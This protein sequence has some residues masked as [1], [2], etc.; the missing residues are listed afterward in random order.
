MLGRSARA[1]TVW[2][3]LAVAGALAWPRL[4]PRVIATGAYGY[5]QTLPADLDRARF[6][7]QFERSRIEAL[8]H[9]D[10]R[11]ATVTVERFVPTHTIY[12]KTDGKVEGSVPDGTGPSRADMS[13]QVL[14]AAAPLAFAPRAQAVA[15]VGLGSGVSAATAAAFEPARLEVIEIERAVWEAVRAVPPLGAEIVPLARAHRLR[16]RIADA[17][18]LL[19]RSAPGS[20][21][22]VIAQPSEPWRGGSAA[23]F[24]RE[25]FRAVA[26]AL[27]PGGIAAQWVQLY[28][29]DRA[30]L[31][32]LLA[33]FESVFAHVAVLRPHGA[34]E[35]ILLGSDR[36]LRIDPVRV[37]QR[38][39]RAAV[40]RWLER[41][42]V[43]GVAGLLG[44]LVAGTEAL[45]RFAAGAPVSTDDHNRIAYRAPRTRFVPPQTADRLA[46]ALLEGAAGLGP[47]FGAVDDETRHE[48]ALAA[49]RAG[50]RWAAEAQLAAVRDPA[51]RLR[52]LGDVRLV[53]R[54]VIGA[55]R[56]WDEALRRDP[57]DEAV[58][59]RL[60]RLRLALGAREGGAR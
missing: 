38:I 6:R 54:D 45:R 55:L 56:A 7:S 32:T 48:I 46:Q 21:D 1:R 40:R 39:E 31:A 25:A 13:T 23:L 44:E 9:R 37:A 47:L 49:A 33:T 4:D 36:P 28:G 35:L 5:V 24:T 19:A 42:E 30:G 11:C 41:A 53:G 12:L 50:N 15:V 58:L 59:Q 8:F 10:G 29:L 16:V 27:R 20:F 60:V 17:R 2:I 34:R 3:V 51:R 43:D 14:L 52:W 18:R 57:G 22:V 26:R